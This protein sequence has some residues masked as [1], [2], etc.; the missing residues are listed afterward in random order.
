MKIGTHNG[1]FHADDVFAVGLVNTFVSPEAE[2]VRTRDEKVLAT[3]DVLI[4]V[5][6]VFDPATRRFDHHQYKAEQRRRSR[7][8]PAVP[9]SSA[10]MVLEWLV[11]T[12][13]LT[14]E[15]GESLYR[16]LI[17]EV[18]LLDNGEGG[19]SLP[20]GGLSAMIS[21]LNPSWDEEPTFDAAF[22]AA[23]A[24]AKG[25][26]SDAL[27]SVRADLRARA[28]VLKSVRADAS[29]DRVLCMDIEV[30][31]AREIVVELGLPHV[32]IVHPSHFGG[33][34]VTT[35]P[36]TREELFAQRLPL[37]AEWA[38]KRGDALN[39]L[40]LAEGADPAIIEEGTTAVPSAV[41]THGGRFCGGHGTRAAV[42]EM[43]RLALS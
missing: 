7:F 36:P 26:I 22:A 20:H 15:E 1:P 32:L 4:D 42:M 37:P 10:G 19:G 24:M 29:T 30:P 35:V 21:R 41:F 28:I 23:V 9:L 38:G 25:I 5:G 2:V 43:A 18:D 11:D 3:C 14:V 39:A 16:E 40:L 13:H 31:T 33:W 12:S 6:A 17:A 34:M 27:K 8:L